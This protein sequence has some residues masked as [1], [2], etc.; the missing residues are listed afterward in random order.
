MIR[1]TDQHFWVRVEQDGT[2][3]AGITRHAQDTLGEIVL[4]DVQAQGRQSENAIVGV[5]ESAK[6]ASDLYMPLDAD[7]VETNAALRD[8][9][10]LINDDPMGTGWILRLARLDMARFETLMNDDAYQAMV[11]T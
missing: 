8:N 3:V 9:P 6:T 7:I 5:V 1:F 11:A 10:C 2:A 4:V